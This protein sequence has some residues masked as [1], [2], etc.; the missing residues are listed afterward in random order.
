[1]MIMIH[2]RPLCSATTTSNKNEN[3]IKTTTYTIISFFIITMNNIIVAKEK[4]DLDHKTSKRKKQY[5]ARTTTRMITLT[6]THT[7]ATGTAFF[8]L[9]SS[10]FLHLFVC[11]DIL[12]LFSSFFS[13]LFACRSKN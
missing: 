6:Q 2:V 13:F 7:F 11:P 1:M 3:E 5:T 9:I 4:S 10:H 8:L 12:L